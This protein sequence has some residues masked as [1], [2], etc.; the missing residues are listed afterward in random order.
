MS[1]RPGLLLQVYKS[2]VWRQGERR[3]IKEYS[4]STGAIRVAKLFGSQYKTYYEWALSGPKSPAYTVTLDPFFV[5]NA[6]SK[7]L[8]HYS[9]VL[10]SGL[11]ADYQHSSS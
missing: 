9:L 5:Q 3:G 7:G 6:A 11:R 2:L 8:I 1:S 10:N 4:R